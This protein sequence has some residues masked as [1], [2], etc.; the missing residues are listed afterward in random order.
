MENKPTILHTEA[1]TGWGGQEIR[2]F[3]ESLRMTARG[4]RVIIAAPEKSLLNKKAAAAGI[5]IFDMEFNKKDPRS[6]LRMA[7]L[8]TRE[9]VDILNTHSSADSWVATIAAYLSGRKPK[10]IRTRHLSTPISR[11]ILSRII[12]DMLPD[13]VITTGEAI[14][15]RMVRHNGFRADKIISIPT[16]VD[17]KRFS[18]KDVRPCIIQT[19]FHIGII[20]VLRNWKG[21]TYLL[22]ALP[23]L[24]NK[25]KDLH[26]YIVGDGP[27]AGNLKKKVRAMGMEGNVFFLG[28]REDI[29]EIMASLDIVVHP[30]YESEGVP[31]SILQAMA[32]HKPVIA[33]DVGAISE[34]VINN[35]TG[36]LL[37][38]RDPALI[39]DSILR[40]Y[41]DPQ[42]RASMGREAG[43]LV[44]KRFS[45]DAMADKVE[46][47]YRGL[48][49]KRGR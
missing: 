24:L 11:S 12:Y 29:P 37:K 28:H 49:K 9:K 39:T 23:A 14:K 43:I 7:S 10:V 18:H 30:S 47:L 22:D 48:G 40:L 13:A 42:L 44:E 25:I 36:I 6:F 15:D 34:A 31:Q 20:G 35:H 21:H 4:Y 41:S 32:M 3:E 5:A 1:S 16:G 33:S 2:V 45:I 38:P 8:I 19:G 27:Q 26:L 17:L 46:R